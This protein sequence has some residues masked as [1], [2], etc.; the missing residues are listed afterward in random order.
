MENNFYFT[1]RVVNEQ[2]EYMIFEKK[3]LKKVGYANYGKKDKSFY[4]KLDVGV[5]PTHIFKCFKVKGVTPI[6]HRK[7]VKNF[8]FTYERNLVRGRIFF[9]GFGFKILKSR[10]RNTFM[11]S[12]LNITLKKRSL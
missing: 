7:S 5:K 2:K 1:Y 4:V 6:H 12:F 11:V 10:N 3:S 8:L 9:K